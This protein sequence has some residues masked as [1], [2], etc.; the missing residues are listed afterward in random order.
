M[1]GSQIDP[2]MISDRNGDMEAL[3]ARIREIETEAQNQQDRLRLTHSRE[4][5]R[6]QRSR[7]DRRSSRDP[8]PEAIGK[9]E[10][11]TLTYATTIVLVVA[12]ASIA[13]GAL[14]SLSASIT[15]LLVAAAVSVAI[16]VLVRND[17]ALL[18][19]LVAGVF[20]DGLAYGPLSV[21]RAVAAGAVLFMVWRWSS[22]SWSPPPPGQLSGSRRLG[23]SCGR[24]QVACGQS[25]SDRGRSSWGSWDWQGPTSQ[26]SRG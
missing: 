3:N 4:Q 18:H 14:V 13:L 12:M 20:L 5:R 8:A 24:S 9:S 25:N 26:P 2:N 7:R 22:G 10:A 17:L 21:G 15:I 23:S 6:H 1:D 19:V 11:R 16:V